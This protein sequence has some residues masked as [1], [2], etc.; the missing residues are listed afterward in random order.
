MYESACLSPTSFTFD[1]WDSL[2]SHSA[3]IKYFEISTQVF[4]APV[5]VLITFMNWRLEQRKSMCTTQRACPNNDTIFTKLM[6][7][8]V[9]LLLYSATHTQ[10]SII[11]NL[12][13]SCHTGWPCCFPVSHGISSVAKTDNI[14]S[15][16]ALEALRSKVCDWWCQ[17]FGRK[18]IRLWVFVPP[19]DSNKAQ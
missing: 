17:S 14:L 9:H 8:K 13:L 11:F 12:V 2:L 10:K 19:E 3:S 18:G 15:W 7:V 6:Y 16:W 1:I 4:L 5:R